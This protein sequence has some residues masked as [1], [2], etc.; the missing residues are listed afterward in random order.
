MKKINI[1]LAA[2]GMS[3]KVFHAPLLSRHK[4]FFLSK[5]VER[6][7]EEVKTIY[8]EVKSVKKFENLLEDKDVEM[9]VVNTPDDT[10]YQYASEAIKAGKHVILEKPFVRNVE[11]GEKLIV[12][13]RKYDRI[14]S[15]FQNRRWDG[16]FLTVS[17]LIK[18]GCL[19]RLVEFES[20]YMRFRNFI[21]PDT[22]KEN[23][24]FGNGII[25]NL[26][27]HMID[28]A[29]CL[30]GM[31]DSLWADVDTLRDDG[32]IDDYYCIHLLYHRLKI[33]LKAS[34]LVREE[35]PRYILH[36]TNG[37]FLKYGIDPQ[38]E[39]LKE[40]HD[41]YIPG[42]GKESESQWGIL[43]TDIDDLHYKGKIETLPGNYAAFYDNIYEAVRNR[44][45]LFVKPEESLNTIRIINECMGK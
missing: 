6:S 4:G 2:F 45:S 16:D 21:Q 35:T 8:P 14:L 36:G 27:S 5:I 1:A 18:N 25:Y 19:G 32:M 39:L 22:W 43:N 20:N 11:D 34:Y 42:W 31:P 40:G 33:T 30:F 44:A 28:Q 15:V 12:L 29:L 37:S 3:G 13:A 26:G 41:P 10:H 9:I 24:P 7:K 17:N 23:L 38:E